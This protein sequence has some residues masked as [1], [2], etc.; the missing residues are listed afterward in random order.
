MCPTEHS[1][2]VC[3]K[4][5]GHKRNIDQKNK[6]KNLKFTQLNTANFLFNVSCARQVNFSC[7]TNATVP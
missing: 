5:T 3:F 4:I 6:N 1:P 7:T 2:K